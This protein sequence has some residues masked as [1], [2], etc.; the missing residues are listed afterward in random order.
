MS[1]LLLTLAIFIIS[2]I[3][4]AVNAR[5]LL[6]RIAPVVSASG[7]SSMPVLHSTVSSRVKSTLA[8]S[9][10]NLSMQNQRQPLSSHSQQVSSFNQQIP[11]IS[12]DIGAASAAHQ[13][14]AKSGQVTLRQEKP[15][16]LERYQEQMSSISDFFNFKDDKD[17][18]LDELVQAEDYD[19]SP[20]KEVEYIKTLEEYVPDKYEDLNPLQKK[21]ETSESYQNFLEQLKKTK[22]VAFKK[23]TYE[24]DGQPVVGFALLPKKTRAN[25]EKHPLV[26]SMRG[27]F[28]GEGVFHEWAKVDLP[29]IMRHYAFLAQNGYAV[30]VSQYRGAE[31]NTNKDEFGGADVNDV[32]KLFDVA[33][34]MGNIDLDN[35]SLN[36]FSRGT[37][38]LYKTLQALKGKIP[39]KAAII[40]GGISDLPTFLKD[41]PKYIKPILEQARPDFNENAQQIAEDISLVHGAEVL[42]DIPTL[43][44]HNENDNVVPIG[45]SQN[46]VTKL[47]EQGS[48]Y[49]FKFFPGKH[50]QILEHND[51]VQK[52]TLD[53]LKK[54]ASE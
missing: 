18:V 12:S 2:P 32:L 44:M 31:G 24:V 41:D 46:L 22:D 38:M 14:L 16:F 7:R 49:A 20:K 43:V 48:E 54:H 28:N 30:L 11:M 39:I 42:K 19:I 53:W 47:K 26:L 33:K 9:G 37:V 50:H 45:L 3:Q 15:S 21:L 35:V 36:A 8:N 5:T 10:L 6:A 4:A 40:K 52:L 25:G 27:G 23:I 1:Q 17:Y 29:W 51:E 34:E 13:R